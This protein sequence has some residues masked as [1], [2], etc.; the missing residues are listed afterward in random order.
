MGTEASSPDIYSK[1][2]TYRRNEDYDSVGLT[3][4]KFKIATKNP[5]AKALFEKYNITKDDLVHDPAKAAIATLIHLSTL[6]KEAKQDLDGTI[7][8]WNSGEYYAPKV[9]KY[10]GMIEAY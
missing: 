6:Y 8:R 1:Y 5:K 9:K 2:E 3:Q 7:T 4:M 10:S